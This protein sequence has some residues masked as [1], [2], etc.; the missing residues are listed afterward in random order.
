MDRRRFSV[1]LLYEESHTLSPKGSRNASRQAATVFFY[2]PKCYTHPTYETVYDL[3]RRDPVAQDLLDQAVQNREGYKTTGYIV[4]SDI[5]RP[6]GNTQA[7]GL[8]L[9]SKNQIRYATSFK[10]GDARRVAAAHPYT[11]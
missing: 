10:Q 6:E 2:L 5:S 11:A 7:K 3:C 9:V 4:T 1:I 8:R